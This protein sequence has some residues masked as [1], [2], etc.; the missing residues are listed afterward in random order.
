MKVLNEAIT[1]I[2]NKQNEINYYSCFIFDFL[3]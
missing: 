1:D 2:E 3:S